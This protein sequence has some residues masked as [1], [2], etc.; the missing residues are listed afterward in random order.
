MSES[1]CDYDPWKQAPCPFC[2]E[3]YVKVYSGI[4]EVTLERSGVTRYDATVSCEECGCGGPTMG[5]GTQKQAEIRAMIAWNRRTVIKAWRQE[6]V[7][8][9]E[10]SEEYS[11]PADD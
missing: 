9:T 1:G 10:A 8:G 5:A 4:C 6:D 3:Q 11:V 7:A 2:G